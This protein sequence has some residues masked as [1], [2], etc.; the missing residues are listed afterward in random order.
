M[1]ISVYYTKDEQWPNLSRDLEVYT[2]YSYDEGG[3][4]DTLGWQHADET[5]TTVRECRKHF[6]FEQMAKCDVKVET[7]GDYLDRMKLKRGMNPFY[8]IRK[9]EVFSKFKH[10][11]SEVKYG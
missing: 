11:G 6:W 4:F 1:E 10:M 2:P 8:D 7:L 3:V 9:M 5:Y